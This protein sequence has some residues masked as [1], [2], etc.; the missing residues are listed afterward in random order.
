MKLLL[1]RYFSTEGRSGP[2]TCIFGYADVPSP[3]LQVPISLAA[4]SDQD[5][6]LILSPE[7]AQ[8]LQL[9]SN[10]IT[11]SAGETGPKVLYCS[12]HSAASGV[13]VLVPLDLN[14]ELSIR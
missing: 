13:F 7:N 3:C 1:L 12:A 6:I 9:M 4:P 8:R 2:L 5:A 10:F 14:A 11:F